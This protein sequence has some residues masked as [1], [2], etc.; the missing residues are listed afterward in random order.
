MQSH[1]PPGRAAAACMCVCTQTH[2]GII[3]LET[4]KNYEAPRLSLHAAYRVTIAMCV[5]LL[6]NAF[7]SHVRAG[8]PHQI[9]VVMLIWECGFV[10]LVVCR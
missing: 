1:F 4:M 3:I 10:A 8:G 6:V 5:C 9:N 7:L 2:V